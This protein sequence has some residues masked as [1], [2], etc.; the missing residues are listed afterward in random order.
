MR[1]DQTYN[2]YNFANQQS[3]SLLSNRSFEGIGPTLALEVRR[4]F[5]ASGLALYASTRGSL[6]IGSA[7]EEAAATVPGH[8][9]ATEDH[10]DR[11][12]PIAE[13]ELGLEYDRPLGQGRLFGQIAFVGQD[14]FGVGNASRSTIHMLPGGDFPGGGYNVDSD[15]VLYGVCFRIGVNY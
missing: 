4:P 9:L 5:G 8:T 7:N 6:V 10:Q 14:W 13:L 15:I 1:V 11:G 3:H 2:A 12:V